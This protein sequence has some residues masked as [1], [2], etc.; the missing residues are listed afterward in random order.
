[1]RQPGRENTDN[2][3]TINTCFRL[4]K[5]RIA[6]V[7]L[8]SYELSLRKRMFSTFKR[9]ALGKRTIFEGC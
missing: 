6:F 7:Q 8:G 2:T 3:A 5:K 1:M 4:A 9:N